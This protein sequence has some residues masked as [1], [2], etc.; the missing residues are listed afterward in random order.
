VPTVSTQTQ[1][2]FVITLAAL[3]KTNE[4]VPDTGCP[5]CPTYQGSEGS[6]TKGSGE[7]FKEVA[8]LPIPAGDGFSWNLGTFESV[9]FKVVVF[10]Y[11]DRYP[12]LDWDWLL[13]ALEEL[14]L[15]GVPRSAATRFMA[16]C[17]LGSA[18]PLIQRFC[19]VVGLW[20]ATEVLP[21]D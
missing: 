13:Q 18:Q 7:L 1:G 11:R 4:L 12:A 15:M 10:H 5:K 16:V 21:K 3:V 17:R 2:I 20:V 14:R 19:Q 8:S 9:Q 6:D